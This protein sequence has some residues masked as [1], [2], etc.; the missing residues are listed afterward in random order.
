MSTNTHAQMN[1]GNATVGEAQSE[2][3]FTTFIAPTINKNR[4]AIG[5][6]CNKFLLEVAN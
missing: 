5:C 3:K 2:N 4:A 6:P 1:S